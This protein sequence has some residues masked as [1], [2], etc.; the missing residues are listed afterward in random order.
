MD[1]KKQKKEKKWKIIVSALI[2]AIAGTL[3]IIAN[4]LINVAL[5]PSKMQ[6]TEIFENITED[7]VEALV[8]TDDIQ[9]NREKAIEETNEWL[10]AVQ[11]QKLS[12]QSEDGYELIARVFWQEQETHKWVMLL[13]GYTGWKEEMY[14]F[15]YQYAKMGYQVIVPDMRCQGESEGDFIGMGWTDRVDN[16]IWLNYIVQQDPEAEIVLHGQS[17]GAS[18]VLM[19]SGDKGLP[20]QVKAV[21]SDSAYTNVYS[22]FKKQITEWFHLPSFPILD[23]ANLMLQIRG[24]Y[25]IREASALEQVKKSSLPTLFIHGSEDTFVPVEMAQELYDAAGGEKKLLVIEGAGHAQAPDKEPE[26]YY[27]TVFSFLESR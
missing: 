5:V 14:P 10:Q 25:N 4:I 19:M 20:T 11:T 9:Q 3:C 27:E 22:M 2:I 26:K 1:R 18:C 12:A 6:E 7:S 21:V 8:Q 17:M 13:H 23:T 16:M 15:A 24:G